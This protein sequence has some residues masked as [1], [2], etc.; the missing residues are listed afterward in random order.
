[1][2]DDCLRKTHVQARDAA[3]VLVAVLL[4]ADG[5]RPVAQAPVNERSRTTDAAASGMGTVAAIGQPRSMPASAHAVAPGEWPRL[6]LPDPIA[7]QAARQ[8]LDMAWD[9]LARTDC[10]GLLSSFIDRSGSSL[11]KRLHAIGVDPQTYLTML[12]FID[13]SRD[14]P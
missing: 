13:G 6:Q 4:C 10:A 5:V 7:R 14:A 11:D 9:R 2:V 8:A 3:V 12:V 1:M